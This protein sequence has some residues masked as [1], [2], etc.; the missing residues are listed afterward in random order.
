MMDGWMDG[1][2]DGQLQ[3]RKV[4]KIQKMATEYS[5]KGLSVFI[6]PLKES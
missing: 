2:M 4:G 6:L 5:T 3:Y 1:W